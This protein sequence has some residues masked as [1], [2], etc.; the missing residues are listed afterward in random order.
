[1]SHR[2]Y[3]DTPITA[4][5]AVLLGAEAHHLQHVLRGR[6]GDEV[7]LLDGS[8]CE[9]VARVSRLARS[10]V[11][12]VVLTSRQVDRELPCQIELG[13]AL[14]KADRQRWLIEKL[15]ELGVARV[16]PLRTQRSVVHPD[17]QSLVKLQRAVKEASKQCGR[18]RLLQ[19]AELQ[20][21]AA[22]L[23]AAPATATRWI[24]DPGGGPL[25]GIPGDGSPCHLAVG[26]EGGWTEDELA[27]ARAAGWQA[28][29][30]GARVLRIETACLVLAAL[31]SQGATAGGAG[32][33][34]AG[35]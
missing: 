15:V 8:G 29:S 13:V 24:A 21:L 32:V 10:Q 16:V 28:I 6:V 20:P 5:E 7:I 11:D 23:Q 34:P 18:T 27:R 3:V 31:W 9:H 33:Q 19:V 2:F 1:M 26:P 30:L 14:P 25:A 22:F 4:G 35:S 12:L 17:P